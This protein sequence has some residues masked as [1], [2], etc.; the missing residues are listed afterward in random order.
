MRHHLWLQGSPIIVGV[1]QLVDDRS[2][3][4]KECVILMATKGWNTH[5]EVMRITSNDT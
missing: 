5:V 4:T 3:G 2:R 1:E